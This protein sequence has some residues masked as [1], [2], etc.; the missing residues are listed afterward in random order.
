[1]R[2][3][4]VRLIVAL[5]LAACASRS[6]PP[7]P[8]FNLPCDVAAVLRDVCQHCH[9]SPPQNDAPFP[10]ITGNDTHQLFT[11][12]PYENAPIWQVM[13]DAVDAG[14]MPPPDAGVAITQAQ[15]QV[16]IGW[17]AAGAPERDGGVCP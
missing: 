12:P 9:T 10:L 1:M 11:A 6:E 4:S 5:G 7:P 15:R 13:G 16:I 2:S 3:E 8:D 17:A 14:V